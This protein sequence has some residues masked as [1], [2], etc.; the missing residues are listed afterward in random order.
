MLHHYTSGLLQSLTN[1]QYLNI[2][3]KILFTPSDHI[4]LLRDMYRNDL[5]VVEE[6]IQLHQVEH[7]QKRTDHTLNREA[8]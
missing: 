6:E 5:Q 7:L 8:E 3:P 4:P 2:L 1:L